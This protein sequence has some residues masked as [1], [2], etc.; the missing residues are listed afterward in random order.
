MLDLTVA[1]IF[2]SC[3]F[4]DVELSRIDF[5]P[6]CTARKFCQQ[7]TIKLENPVSFPVIMCWLF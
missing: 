4:L 7:T 1:L 2:Y 5:T 3:L 6:N